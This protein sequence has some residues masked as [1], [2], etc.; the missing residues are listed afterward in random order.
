MGELGEF[1]EQGVCHV[2]EEADPS[3]PG[4]VSVLADEKA[5]AKGRRLEKNQL[6][7][8][9]RKVTLWGER[10]LIKTPLVKHLLFTQRKNLKVIVYVFKEQKN[11]LFDALILREEKT[12]SFPKVLVVTFAILSFKLFLIEPDTSV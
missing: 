10:V 3:E 12:T 1:S 4:R 2:S 11:K 5:N 9:C 7:H 6:C 8:H